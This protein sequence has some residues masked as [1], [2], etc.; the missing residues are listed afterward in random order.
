MGTG[1][2]QHC[3][4]ILAPQALGFF[5]AAHMRADYRNHR[6]RLGSI[7]LIRRLVVPFEGLYMQ[8]HGV[9]ADRSRLA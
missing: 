4:S 7:Q 5:H 3:D 2:S 9:V 1:P 6:I 8:M